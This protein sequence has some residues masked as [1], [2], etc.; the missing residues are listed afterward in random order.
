MALN[1]VSFKE[2]CGT[3]INA[4]LRT[5]IQKFLKHTSD[6]M[7]KD[8]LIKSNTNINTIQVFI[9]I[10]NDP[11]LLDQD[12]YVSKYF[13]LSISEAEHPSISLI[14]STSN[15]IAQNIMLNMTS[16]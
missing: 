11:K 15:H 7:F 14:M 2:K 13:N 1:T 10:S 16:I 5:L 8:A 9:S 12:H 6:A 4:I 3:L